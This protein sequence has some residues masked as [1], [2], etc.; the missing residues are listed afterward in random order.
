MGGVCVKV[1]VIGTSE[2]VGELVLKKLKEKN[3][4]SVAVIKD[5]HRKQDM[6]KLGATEVVVNEGDHFEEVFADCNAVIYIA[7]SSQRT[8]E[9]KTILIDHD[10]VIDSIEEAK[11]MN[12]ER[13]ILMSAIRA[14]ETENSESSKVGEKHKPDERLREEGFNYTIIR[15]GHLTDK[16]G[17]GMITIGESLDI[18]EGEISKEDVASVL[19]EVLDNQ[20]SFHKTFDVISGNVPIHEAFYH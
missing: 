11:K 6:E 14:N 3:H 17:K 10:E 20:D 15:P 1:A 16:P 12:I 19:V 13:F 18:D 9:N 4:Q 8:G 2:S 5:E 7:G